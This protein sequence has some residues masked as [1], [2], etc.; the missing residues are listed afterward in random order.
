MLIRHSFI[1]CFGFTICYYYYCCCYKYLSFCRFSAWFSFHI[2]MFH[3][4]LWI[5]NSRTAIHRHTLIHLS[6]IN[7]VHIVFM[8]GICLSKL[9]FTFASSSSSSFS[10]HQ[11]IIWIKYACELVTGIVQ[12][13]FF[14]LSSVE[15][16]L[17]L[18]VVL[19]IC[20][21]MRAIAL[22]VFWLDDVYAWCV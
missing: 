10:P 21:L 4:Q 19:S 1:Y 16:T 13:F 6:F 15:W 5:L 14:S 2:E 18:L 11:I 17:L 22:L 7:T 8:Y 20:Y 12:V 9:F 3:T